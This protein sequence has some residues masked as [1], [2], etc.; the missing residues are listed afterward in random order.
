MKRSLGPGR[1]DTREVSSIER[2][3]WDFESLMFPTALLGALTY[4]P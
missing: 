1:G 3:V 4:L 2:S